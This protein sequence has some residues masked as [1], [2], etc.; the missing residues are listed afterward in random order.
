MCCDLCGSRA[1]LPQ[2]GQL[3]ACQQPRQPPLWCRQCK[4]C[5]DVL[6][7]MWIIACQS[8][9]DKNLLFKINRLLT[10]TA[11]HPRLSLTVNSHHCMA[12]QTGSCAKCGRLIYSTVST[13]QACQIEHLRSASNRS[14]AEVPVVYSACGCFSETS[15][16]TQSQC[17]TTHGMTTKA[18]YWTYLHCSNSWGHK[19]RCTRP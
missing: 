18:S 16:W 15:G 13:A 14:A 19:S 6:N 9:L 10:T 3:I 2:L 7:T 8:P 4:L 1:A 11:A 17:G 5:R 12:Q